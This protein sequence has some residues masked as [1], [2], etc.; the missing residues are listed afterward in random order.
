M[1]HFRAR[2]SLNFAPHRLTSPCKFGTNFSMVLWASFLKGK[3]RGQSEVGGTTPPM[4]TI[5]LGATT[6][7]LPYHPAGTILSFSHP[8]PSPGQVLVASLV[9]SPRPSFFKVLSPWHHPPFSQSC[10]LG[11]FI[12]TTEK[13]SGMQVHG[14]PPMWKSS[15]P[16]PADQGW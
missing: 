12:V 5:G 4:A 10:C 15:L 6:G 8:P 16:P 3:C 7:S 9:M 1:L 2:P 14:P 11:P 13:S